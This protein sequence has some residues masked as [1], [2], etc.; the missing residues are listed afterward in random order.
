[1]A[2][3]ATV[4]LVRTAGVHA[5]LVDRERRARDVGPL[6]WT[7]EQPAYHGSAERLAALQAG[8]PVDIP[9]TICRRCAGRNG[10]PLVDARGGRRRRRDPVLR[11]RRGGVAGREQ[12]LT[13]LAGMH[14]VSL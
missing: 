14:G 4:S 12:P 9:P 2:R 7:P 5:W 6:P 13:V 3:A 11:R 10:L 1:M 8:E